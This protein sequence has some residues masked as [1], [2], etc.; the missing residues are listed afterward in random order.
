MSSDPGRATARR[1][2][3]SLAEAE[4][5]EDLASARRRLRREFAAA[6]YA[7]AV[8]P[9]VLTG[10]VLYLGIDW[11]SLAVWLAVTGGAPFLWRPW[12]RTRRQVRRLEAEV[13]RLRAGQ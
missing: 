8:G 10:V 7:T 13:G 6:A 9:G 5:R 2:A 3:V 1:G 11:P 12:W 4:A